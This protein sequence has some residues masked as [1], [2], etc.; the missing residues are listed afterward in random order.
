M[1][2]RA[3]AEVAKILLGYSETRPLSE[4]RPSHLHATVNEFI[5][6]LL[7]E[8]DVHFAQSHVTDPFRP[9]PFPKRFWRLPR[10]ESG[11]LTGHVILG[12]EPRVRTLG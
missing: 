8:S 3:P 12:V 2:Y 7:S 9:T 11:A 6:I 10:T 4:S 1:R 5:Q